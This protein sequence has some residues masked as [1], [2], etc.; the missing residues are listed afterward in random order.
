MLAKASDGADP[1]A[2]CQGSGSHGR[3]RPARWRRIALMAAGLAGTGLLLAYVLFHGWRWAVVPS[4]APVVGVSCDTAWHSELGISTKNYEIS[5]IR[6]GARM[7]WLRPGEARPDDLLDRIDALLL[8]GGGDGSTR[9]SPTTADLE[10]VTR[11]NAR[12]SPP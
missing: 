11:R 1:S 2:P 7:E 12:G 3:R 10:A 6:A 8:A 9:L 5:L 4:D